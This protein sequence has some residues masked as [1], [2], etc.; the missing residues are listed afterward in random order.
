MFG[1][2]SFYIVTFVAKLFAEGHS[3]DCIR[4]MIKFSDPKIFAP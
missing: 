3:S 1:D 2:Y 4:P